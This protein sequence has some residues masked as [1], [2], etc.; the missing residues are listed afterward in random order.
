MTNSA[1]LFPPRFSK[2]FSRA[3]RGSLVLVTGLLACTEVW[4]AAP[5]VHHTAKSSLVNGVSQS[6]L[7]L[8]GN[9][10]ELG[11]NPTGAF[12]THNTSKPAGFIGTSVRSQI[13]M[14]TDLDGF[15]VGTAQSFDYFMP[16]SPFVGFAAGYK[17][18]GVPTTGTNANSSASNV[19]SGM[20]ATSL[21]D[22]TTGT[23]LGAKSI[24]TLGGKLQV[25]QEVSFGVND[26]FF[27]ILVTLKNISAG[28][29]DSCRYTWIVD[30]DNV[31]DVG[32]DY[33]TD[34]TIVATFAAGDGKAIV[35]GSTTSSDPVQANLV[36]YSTDNRAR[37]F[38]GNA[39][40]VYDSIVYDTAPAKNAT[41][42]QDDW[43]GMTW[44]VGTLAAGQST[45]FSLYIAM[46]NQN[47]SDIEDEISGS[48]NNAPTDISLSSTTIAQAAGV[49]AVVGTLSAT[50][51][52][53]G[54]T[55]TFTLV[56]G[57]GSTDN[58]SFNI[59]GST[60]RANNAGALSPGTYSVR[61]RT[62]DSGTGNL[63]FEKAFTITVTS[64]NNAPTDI[65][66]SSSTISQSAGVNAVIG[67]LSATDADSGDTHTFT[68]VSGTGSTNNTLFNISGSSLRA[69][70]AGALSTGDY[71]VRVR[72]TDSG[73]GNLTFEKA[74]TITVGD[75]VAPTVTSVTRLTPSSS[76]ATAPSVVFHVT[77]SESVAGVDA[78]DFALVA[79]GGTAGSVTSVSASSGASVD[80]TV[81]NITGTGTL[82]LDV[83]SGGIQDLASNVMTSGFNSGEVY[84]ITA[85]PGIN[86]STTASGTFG[87]AFS[88][89]ITATNSPTSFSAT[90]LPAG[91]SL[92]PS[93]GVI[94]G[95]PT[96]AGDAAVN[97][98]ATN[99]T[100][101]G[102][103]T[104]ALSIAKAT[105]TVSFP[106]FSTPAINTPTTLNAT[107]SSG[108][109][110]TFTVVSGDATISSGKLT[111]TGTSSVT[112][113]ATQAGNANYQPA[114]ATQILA[115]ANLL[116]QSISFEQPSDKSS[117]DAPFPLSAT[118]TSGLPVTLT[119]IDG[120]ALLSGNTI[121]LTGAPGTVVVRAIQQGN[122]IYAPAAPVV[123]NIVVSAVGQQIYFG[124]L[125]ADGQ[126][127]HVAAQI[128]QD[129]TKGNLIGFLPELNQG[130]VIPFDLNSGSFRVSL[131]LVG[132]NSSVKAAKLA[133]M[134]GVVS[135]IDNST[136]TN[137]ARVVGKAEQ[138][139]TFNGQVVNGVLTGMIE[140][141][142]IPFVAN[143]VA[144]TGATQGIA[145][146]YAAP[147]LDTANG[148]TY[149]VVGTR[150]EV[151]VLTVM[152]DSVQA[153]MGAVA[154]DGKFTVTT[155]Q[156][157]VI[158][159]TV[160]LNT[161]QIVG[162][163]TAPGKTPESFAGLSSSTKRTD[164]LLNLSARARL[165]N[166]PGGSVLITGFIIAGPEPKT[167]LLRGVGPTL[168]QFGI[169]E[170]LQNPHIRLYHNAD[171]VAENED[172]SGSD[173]V[174]ANERIG[175]FPLAEGGKDAAMLVTLDPGA[176]TLQVL[177]GTGVALAEMYDASER[178]QAEFQRLVNV[179]ARG[180]VTKGEGVLIGGFIVGGNSPK[181]VLVR[182][183]G[184]ALNKYGVTGTL[185]DPVLEVFAG[186]DVIARNDNWETP[187]MV[188]NTQAAATG[189]EIVAATTKINAFALD[190]GSKDAA[191]IVTLAP[192]AYT[193][194]V[195][196]ATGDT[197]VALIEVYEIPE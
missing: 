3:R 138:T 146:Y 192:G 9:F 56:S 128:T 23:T 26:K 154:P 77:F 118:A 11:I 79:A 93:T 92:N 172:W 19:Q 109:P 161:T 18:G 169:T 28:S 197:G 139:Y 173:I 62:T 47:L 91:L 8:G 50:D 34:N 95:T 126:K 73:F 12:G 66:L 113:K 184:T 187:T 171:L 177:G 87:S 96:A 164:R 101:T 86:S 99:A 5:G 157:T 179:S 1:R 98:G 132:A 117:T 14:V 106:A 135:S 52:D 148:G 6:E 100:G 122:A 44:D 149:A 71:S 150:G 188:A 114:S 81:G 120:P 10:L 158:S 163:V 181:R 147:A 183:I 88:Y 141:L 42:T 74:F 103:A 191:V 121:T 131:P 16:G 80:V 33:T 17:I 46:S 70:N 186:S 165:T 83:V 136:T 30:P 65:A 61:V 76:N 133:T 156:Q 94:S 72:A 189:A 140:E 108:L 24:V 123:R 64:S 57:T 39:S 29:L 176:Y 116:T 111:I 60:L 20:P 82:R 125:G 178:P 194:H 115:G 167:V 127:G 32:G 160:D 137:T 104:L 58:A 145:G 63:T 40:S 107:A 143:I 75:G 166:T 48:T 45:S 142:S 54:D 144:P 84:T 78:S 15:G 155:A 168:K 51:A 185:A 53:S 182:G 7:F 35:Q 27:T 129:S 85:A 49:N 153:D 134:D 59:S 21:T 31:V 151:F 105:Q 68:L 110:I 22:T 97:L 119:V 4:A 13:G 190:A 175:V 152:R 67:T 89:T 2:L 36:L 162:S 55:Q 193:A 25:T 130:F 69:N 170:A 159:G 90:G 37:G 174:A 112:V 41:E 124:L 195:V 102:T 43:I 196:S 38:F 180:E